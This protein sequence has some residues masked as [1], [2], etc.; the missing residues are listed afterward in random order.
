MTETLNVERILCGDPV[1]IA[2][3]TRVAETLRLLAMAETSAALVTRGGRVFGLVTLRECVYAALRYRK[4]GEVVVADLMYAPIPAAPLKTS[5]AEAYASMTLHGLCHLAVVDEQEGFSGLVSADDCWRALQAPLATQALAPE[6]AMTRAVV[7]VKETDSLLTAIRL[8]ARHSLGCV[9]VERGG[10][11][12]GM[13]SVETLAPLLQHGMNLAA[14]VVGERMDRRAPTL[15]LWGS[16]AEALSLLQERGARRLVMV[17]RTGRIAGLLSR[18]DLLRHLKESARHPPSH[19][20]HTTRDLE[21]LALAAEDW[22]AMADAGEDAVAVLDPEG[23]IRR[24]NAACARLAGYEPGELRGHPAAEAFCNGRTALPQLWLER[25]AAELI[26]L[27][28]DP[29]NPFGIPVLVESRPVPD[30]GSPYQGSLLKIRDLSRLFQ[31]EEQRRQWCAV[32]E[33][34]QEGV[35]VA[36]KEGR[37]ELANHAFCAL[38]GHPEQGLLNLNLRRLDAE[39][40]GEP[41][42]RALANAVFKAG[43]WQGEVLRRNGAPPCWLTVAAVEDD[44]NQATHYLGLVAESPPLSLRQR[45]PSRS[46]APTASLLLESQLRRAI[47]LDELSL[48]YQPQVEISGG[49]VVGIEALARWN[50]E[51]Q[52]TID[53]SDF[54]PLAERSGLSAPLDLWVLRQAC[55]QARRW[56]DTGLSF[57]RVAVNVAGPNLRNPGFVEAVAGI[58]EETGL[59]GSHLELDIAEA[60][61]LARGL[62]LVGTLAA[63]RQLGVGIAI[64]DFGA[65]HSSLPLLASLPVHRLKLDRRLLRELRAG[66]AGVARA[67]IGLGRSLGLGVV[68]KGVETEWQ[69]DEL[70]QHGYGEAQGFLY[71][72]PASA[73]DTARMLSA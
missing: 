33:N 3:E 72:H 46:A 63:L 31:H 65:G 6:R 13:L 56:R 5:L 40:S 16:R 9:V 24:A 44:R 22:K 27:A 71:G 7:A 25:K 39:E 17:D 48:C 54:L 32:L 52:R 36:T 14:T 35:L 57:G 34:I 23:R 66:G 29:R 51:Q 62:E 67:A 73:E 70:L 49:R 55:Q 43:P 2:P 69:R 64:D 58:L 60:T 45:T 11:P 4:V 15:P 28:N 19:P 61:L 59:P 8:M 42:F 41:L 50:P 68:A 21:A 37:I 10:Y 30:D 18:H 47:E 20:A 53:P 38:T 26:L 1:T 12:V